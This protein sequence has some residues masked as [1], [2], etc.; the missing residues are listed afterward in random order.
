MVRTPLACGN[1]VYMCE[2]SSTAWTPFR[3]SLPVLAHSISFGMNA[4]ILG[5]FFLAYLMAAGQRERVLL[6]RRQTSRVRTHRASCLT[7]ADR[8]DRTSCP[9][10]HSQITYISP[11]DLVTHRSPLPPT[12]ADQLLYHL[13]EGLLERERDEN[14]VHYRRVPLTMSLSISICNKC[15]PAL[16][17]V[18]S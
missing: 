9:I 10:M 6:I 12:C 2:Q 15:L 14:V 13:R 11:R 5:N 17:A 7:G 16:L 8:G 1:I 18:P 4:A 3:Q